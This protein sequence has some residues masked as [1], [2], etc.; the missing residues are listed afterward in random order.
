MLGIVL[1]VTTVAPII[2]ILKDTIAIHPG[3]IDANMTGKTEGYSFA[4]Y[5][6]LFT[7]RTAKSN[8]WTPLINTLLLSTISCVVSII[9]GGVFAFLVTR[10]NLKFRK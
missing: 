1:T 2:A 7:S 4:N 10:T 9:F 3:T 8:L 6:D 5:I